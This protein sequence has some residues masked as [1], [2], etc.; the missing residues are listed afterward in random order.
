MSGCSA[1]RV[2]C[3]L[4][5]PRPQHC[6]GHGLVSMSSPAR[7]CVHSYPG[8]RRYSVDIFITSPLPRLLME[9]EI[10]PTVFVFVPEVSEAGLWRQDGCPGR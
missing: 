6:L 1:H 4:F 10:Q 8:P 9:G 2:G 3:R 5:H 7:E